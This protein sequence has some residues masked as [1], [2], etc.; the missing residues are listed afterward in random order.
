MTEALKFSHQL[1]I[2]HGDIKPSNIMLQSNG[3][4]KLGDFGMARSASSNSLQALG[5]TPNYLA[6]ELLEGYP[7]SIQSDMYALGVT[8]YE[9]SFGHRP[10]TLSGTSVSEW[11][12]SHRESELTFPRPWPEAI[13]ENWKVILRRLLSRDPKNRYQTYDELSSALLKVAPA[14]NRPARTLPRFIAAG[15]DYTLVL[16]AVGIVQIITFFAS[17]WFSKQLNLEGIGWMSSW[18]AN[19]PW[20]VEVL[21]VLI[22]LGLTSVCF[23]PI[24][25]YTLA[26]GYW[27]Q[28]L[29]RAL[30]HIRVINQF[31]LR[32]TRRIL[33]GRSVLRMAWLWMLISVLNLPLSFFSNYLDA[34]LLIGVTLFTAIEIGYMMFVENGSS[35]HDRWFKTRVV[36][37]ENQQ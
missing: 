22:A 8:L 14:Q 34:I 19:I 23:L 26:I 13:P 10:V 35:L 24:V 29:G 7:A 31:G 11:A 12:K 21:R 2:I 36:I 30:M 18:D 25:V 3:V 15:I 6:P 5:G 16:I 28:S 9:M 37:D 4:A 20:Y 32:P 17:D 1:D 27:R 33:M